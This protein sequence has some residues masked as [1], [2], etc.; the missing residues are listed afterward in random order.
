M[1]NTGVPHILEHTTLCGSQKF[2]VR[3]PFMKM[4]NRSLATFMNAMT[5]RPPVFTHLNGSREEE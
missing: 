3:D 2:P 1:D 4:L 5:G